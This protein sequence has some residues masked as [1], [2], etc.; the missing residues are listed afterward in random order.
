MI[1]FG[2]GIYLRAPYSSDLDMMFK[3]RNDPRNWQWFR[4]YTTLNPKNH[5]EWYDRMRV[6]PTIEMLI[7]CDSDDS[8][9]A[10][11]G[12][13]SI[14]RVNSR[15]EVSYYEV[16]ENVG[17]S[18]LECLVMHAFLNQNLNQVWAEVFNGN[19]YRMKFE[20]V[21]FKHDGTLREFYFRNGQYIDA[22][23]YSKIR[24]FEE[25]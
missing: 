11:M 3:E 24:E 25:V 15:A 19:P 7:A 4:Q 2:I 17:T 1:D 20:K 18:P 5:L 9:L 10:V 16:S 12:L 21:G 6:D 23:R 13:T 14:D 22:H 8:R